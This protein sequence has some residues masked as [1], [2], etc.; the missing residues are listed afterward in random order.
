VAESADVAADTDVVSRGDVSM[1][2]M[3]TQILMLPWQVM[4]R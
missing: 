3:M 2:W 4:W 1:T